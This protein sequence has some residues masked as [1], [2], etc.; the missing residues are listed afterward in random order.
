M[1]EGKTNLLFIF[2]GDKTVIGSYYPSRY[3]KLTE[4]LRFD[5]KSFLFVSDNDHT[6]HKFKA[7]PSE[8]HL[9]VSDKMYIC[10]GNTPS[11]ADGIRTFEKNFDALIYCLPSFSYKY[12]EQN[13]CE[14]SKDFNDTLKV[15]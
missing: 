14:D 6:F 11:Y 1:L 13:D 9:S 2:I 15:R 5:N 7:M 10:H 3:P 4:K 12:D 8:F